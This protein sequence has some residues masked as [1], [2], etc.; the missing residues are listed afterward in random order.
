[1]TRHHEVRAAIYARRSTEEQSASLDRQIGECEQFIE[2][3]GWTVGE[4][5]TDSKSGWKPDVPRPSFDRMMRDATAGEFD[6]LVVWEVSRLSRQEGDDSALAMIWRL[7]KAGVEVHSVAERS[8]GNDLA[9]D[10]T[11]LIKSH[12]AKEESDTKSKR[13]TSGKRRGALNGVYQGASPPFGYRF[14]HREPRGSRTIKVYEADPETA[15]ILRRIY[16]E[17]IA[18]ESPQR[19]AD[20]LTTEGITPP[21]AGVNHTYR[22][23]NEPVWHQATIRS[24][25]S[26]P[27]SAGFATYRKQRIKECACA[28]L[29]DIAEGGQR[30]EEAVRR[31]NDCAHEWVRSANVPGAIDVETWERARRIADLRSEPAKGRQ[32]N[33]SGR[34]NNID[35]AAR[36]LLAGMVW[37]GNCG[38]RI[39]IRADGRAGRR[40]DPRDIYRCRGRRVGQCDL[41][42]IDRED[43]DE[44]VRDAFVRQFVEVMDVQATVE[45]ERERL[46]SIR[47]ARAG[48]IR[49]ELRKVEA[50]LAQEREFH[51]RFTAD[52]KRGAITAEQW[53]RLDAEVAPRIAEA[54]QAR[55]NLT[56]ALTE[57]EGEIDTASIDRLLDHLGTLRE[58]VQGR[59]TADSTP[60][61]NLQLREVFEQ[62]AVSSRPNDEGSGTRVIVEPRLRPEWMPE[63][64]GSATPATLDFADENAQGVEVA[65]LLEPVLRKVD[66]TRGL[67]ICS[68]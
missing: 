12:A 21:R 67:I 54:E 10:L 3:E 2:R 14:S 41:P 68:S 9:D 49:E 16:M 18:G 47:S 8:T 53:G 64:E 52:W 24:L 6:V 5:Y 27:L 31:W 23:R 56:A 38:E 63:V 57:A 29:D 17:Y 62:F 66:L 33:R 35:T 60:A 19:I 1:M 42:I 20:R 28:S 26:N 55:G 11:L 13:V 36:F 44:A 30:R 45:R 39:G 4:T 58:M 61:L 65:E 7:R 50:T 25:V 15:P 48:V 32:G 40:E 37:C 46:L 51:D 22:R 43:L 59:L 34:G